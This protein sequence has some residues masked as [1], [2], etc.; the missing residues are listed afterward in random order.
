MEFPH[1]SDGLWQKTAPKKSWKLTTLLKKS[2]LRTT[3]LFPD[4]VIELMLPISNNMVLDL[5]DF[6]GPKEILRKTTQK[7]STTM[8]AWAKE[9]QKNTHRLGQSRDL[10]LNCTFFL[11]FGLMEMDGTRV[12]RWLYKIGIMALRW[13]LV[14]TCPDK[15]GLYGGI[16]WLALDGPGIW[17]EDFG[18]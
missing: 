16:D 7:D 18:F 4:K 9:N 3:P 10:D 12:K 11:G 17:G 13:F 14:L 5:L 2:Y 6:R 8:V 1:F 15:H